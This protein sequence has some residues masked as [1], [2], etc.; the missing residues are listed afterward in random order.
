MVVTDIHAL[1]VK[2]ATAK[3]VEL[4]VVVFEVVKV[5]EE[6]TF[7][8]ITTAITLED[9]I[10]KAFL[11]LFQA[12]NLDREG[13]KILLQ[14]VKKIIEEIATVKKGTLQDDRETPIALV[15]MEEA[16]GVFTKE[17][18]LASFRG[19][20]IIASVLDG[21]IPWP[22]QEQASIVVVTLGNFKVV[23]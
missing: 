12:T 18:V 16:V 17:E 5:S 9:P 23:A 2:S 14:K 3:G 22:E 1:P 10:L 7:E 6:P 8:E 13:S 19:A 11:E 21:D 4:K 20:A 15:Q